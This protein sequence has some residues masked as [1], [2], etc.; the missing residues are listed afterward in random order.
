MNL[1]RRDFLYGSAAAITTLPL[2]GM[3][4]SSERLTIGIASDL[5]IASDK[6]WQKDN[7]LCKWQCSGAIRR[8]LTYFRSKEVDAVVLCGDLA[9]NGLTDELMC[10][11]RAWYDIFPNDC[12]PSGKKSG[13]DIH[14]RKP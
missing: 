14:S 11:S 3:A 4:K 5:H 9:D 7:P 13:E 1:G 6:L 12:L 10:L 2:S 8:A